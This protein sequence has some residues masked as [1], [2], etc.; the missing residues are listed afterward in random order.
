LFPGPDD[1]STDIHYIIR[2]EAENIHLRDEAQAQLKLRGVL[3]RKYFYPLTSDASFGYS[4]PNPPVIPVARQAS[5][6]VLALP[7]HGE[8][9]KGDVENIAKVLRAVLGSKSR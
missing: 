1:S 2:F 4:H 5:R 9:G 3:A 8:V 7:F 6:D